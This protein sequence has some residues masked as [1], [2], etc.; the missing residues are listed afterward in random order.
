MGGE[1]R[2][3]ERPAAGGAGEPSHV[4]V[5]IEA[6]GRG[7]AS[8]EEGKRLVRHLLA[9]CAS[10]SRLLGERLSL[11][12]GQDA[13]P[14]EVEVDGLDE[15]IDRALGGVRDL[16]RRIGLERWGAERLVDE[17]A[18]LPPAHAR[19]RLRSSRRF[20][21]RAV[22]EAL[23]VRSAAARHDDPAETLRWA[24]DAVAVAERMEGPAAVDLRA[25]ASMELG[26]ARRIANDLAG[27]ERAF[28]EA[29]RW[30][31]ATGRSPDLRASFLF[32]LAS[33]RHH[34]RR[35][36]EALD[37]VRRSRNAYRRL[38]DTVGA[39]QALLK[40]G[41][42]HTN[43]GDVE[44][45][46]Q[47]AWSGLCLLG[48][49]ADLELLLPGI[50]NL[51]CLLADHGAEATAVE[52][53]RTARPIYART[54]GE[55]DLARLDW[56]R[57][58]LLTRLGELGEAEQVLDE[59]RQRFAAAELP[60]EV[61]LVSLDL[62]EIF[63]R[64]GRTQ[65]LSQLVGT[66]LPIFRRLAVA[67]EVLATLALLHR[68]VVGEVERLDLIRRLATRLASPGAGRCSPLASA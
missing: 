36:R 55:L 54:A 29:R 35:H 26:N 46:L 4:A 5:E 20:W 9:G 60:Y 2:S 42:F 40:E 62:A 45:G 39:A 50:H 53:M 52:L 11:A 48:P 13:P 58:R 41:A 14:A 38:G 7:Q 64:E 18:A 59:V 61:A 65:A 43:S 10:C 19:M 44:K 3:H 51:V 37:L 6:L 1:L 68:S 47:A 22:C 57:G 23:L 66:M 33:L 24:E 49:E 16:P 30:V 34:Q 17:L 31:E 67:P 28:G 15:V 21:R 25:R 32:L 63:A 27:A 12:G 56:V 8:A